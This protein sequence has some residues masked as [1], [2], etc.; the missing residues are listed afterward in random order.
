[1]KTEVHWQECGARFRR[2][3][4][5]VKNQPPN[6]VSSS[7]SEASICAAQGWTDDVERQEGFVIQQFRY[8]QLQIVKL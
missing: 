5:C 2:M 6:H 7:V 8:G 3:L 1:M 4:D